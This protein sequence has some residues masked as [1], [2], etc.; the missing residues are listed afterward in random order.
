MSSAN[1]PTRC[2]GLCVPPTPPAFPTEGLLVPQIGVLTPPWS[3]SLRVLQRSSLFSNHLL[4]RPR[5]LVVPSPVHLPSFNRGI[6]SRGTLPACGP[7]TCRPA[8]ALG[9]A[10]GV[11][12][13]PWLCAKRAGGWLLNLPPSLA[14]AL[15]STPG[16]VGAAR[17]VL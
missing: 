14:P 5:V 4:P 17:L 1:V 2:A 13:Q 11:S 15:P 3:L 7:H 9:G 6:A 16:S 12:L 8:W 10:A